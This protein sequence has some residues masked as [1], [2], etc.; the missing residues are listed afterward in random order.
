MS[1]AEMLQNAKSRKLEA[2]KEAKRRF[3]TAKT[4]PQ[5]VYPLFTKSRMFLNE[6]DVFLPKVNPFYNEIISWIPPFYI[7]NTNYLEQKPPPIWVNNKH[8][9][10]TMMKDVNENSEIAVDMENHQSHS[11]RDM[12]CVIQLSTRA[13]NYVIHVP[14]CYEFIVC[15]LKSVLESIEIVKIVHGGANDITSFQ[16]DFRIFPQAVID[17]Q[18]VY[19]YVTEEYD[20]GKLISLKT[21]IKEVLGSGYIND[22]D[23]AAQLADWRHDPLPPQMMRYAEKDSSLLLLT[24]QKL[25]INLRDGNW[26]HHTLNP[27]MKSN[28]NTSK[29]Y[30]FPHIPTILEDATRYEITDERMEMFVVLHQWRLNRAKEVDEKP[31][32]ILNTKELVALTLAKPKDIQELTTI[33]YKQRLPKW[34]RGVEDHLISLVNPILIQSSTLEVPS[35]T[36]DEFIEEFYEAE[37]IAFQDTTLF[38]P[39]NKINLPPDAIIVEE[40][41]LEEVN[42]KETNDEEPSPITAA[43]DRDGPSK[44]TFKV[45][46]YE[47]GVSNI[48][49]E[50]HQC[51]KVKYPNSLHPQYKSWITIPAPYQRKKPG[52]I[53]KVADQYQSRRRQFNY[54]RNRRLRRMNIEIKRDGSHVKR[55]C[56]YPR[57]PQGGGGDTLGPPSTSQ[58]HNPSRPSAIIPLLNCST[59]SSRPSLQSHTLLQ[60]SEPVSR[61]LVT[62]LDT[63][64]SPS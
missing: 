40:D 13:K 7:F 32:E 50:S 25:K 59:W 47:K 63:L 61:R 38:I 57:H 48:I 62:F 44:I 17:T 31:I 39:K 3:G 23:N 27:F 9:F 22:D 19:N 37:E 16:R 26:R 56:N 20:N 34:I 21:M 29:C 30:K 33:F 10:L 5:D 28:N 14:S 45:S 51:Q 24:W 43:I 54:R 12:S 35:L 1:D 15:D 49:T 53:N 60:D 2:F 4:R 11:F 18:F 42:F 8:L 46:N 52:E 64:L 6:A 41:E 55:F 58:S 36:Q